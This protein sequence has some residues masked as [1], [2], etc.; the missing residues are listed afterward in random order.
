MSRTIVGCMRAGQP[1]RFLLTSR[2][3]RLRAGAAAR[4]GRQVGRGERTLLVDGAAS[5]LDCPRQLKQA[6]AQRALAVLRGREREQGGCR[7][8]AVHDW[9]R[10]ASQLDE[11][12]RTRAGPG[13]APRVGG[14]TSMCAMTEKLRIR[15]GGKS[16]MSS[17]D[18]VGGARR[19][20]VV[21]NARGRPA[22]RAAAGRG[23]GHDRGACRTGKSVGR[24][25]ESRRRR[26]DA[27]VSLV[28]ATSRG[29]SWPQRRC[30]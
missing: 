12:T 17:L 1:A 20:V 28:G 5:A 8:S 4:D 25:G 3:S 15:S 13:P 9:R 24:T 27:R 22:R 14:R 16:A 2:P 26:T 19:E 6:V 29:A 10:R 18:W 30:S 23:G 21:A 7:R 11:A